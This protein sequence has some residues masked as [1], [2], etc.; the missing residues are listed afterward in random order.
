MIQQNPGQIRKFRKSDF[1]RKTDRSPSL[2]DTEAPGSSSRAT[3]IVRV[4]S[5]DC[6]SGVA[7]SHESVD[8]HVN[9]GI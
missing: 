1:E 8:K 2:V 5:I 3:V 7:F 6:D 9:H 4:R